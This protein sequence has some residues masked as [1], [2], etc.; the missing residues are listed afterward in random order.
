MASCAGGSGA[1]IAAPRTSNSGEAPAAAGA[2]AAVP[3]R[4]SRPLSESE[5]V[6]MAA[7]KKPGCL[8]EAGGAAVAARAAG[9]R[10]CRLPPSPKAPTAG[11][12]GRWLAAPLCAAAPNS[13]KDGASVGCGQAQ[14]SGRVSAGRPG[15]G[16]AASRRRVDARAPGPVRLAPGVGARAAQ[17]PEITCCSKQTPQLARGGRGGHATRHRGGREPGAEGGAHPAG[18]RQSPSHDQSR[19]G[20]PAE[21]RAC[22]WRSC[23]LVGRPSAI[24]QRPGA[25]SQGCSGL[26][27]IGGRASRG[28]RSSEVGLLGRRGGPQLIGPRPG[29]QAAKC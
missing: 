4:F 23:V 12:T 25:R 29:G 8:S 17:L 5:V 22:G 6:R 11:V 26:A 19:A 15:R 3:D 10:A 13:H 16:D 2:G 24:P 14:Q 18:D 7:L 20:A 9:C 28:L 27:W 21:L 1:S